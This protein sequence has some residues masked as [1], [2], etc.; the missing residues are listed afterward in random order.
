[1][2]DI[3]D[4]SYPRALDCGLY[5]PHEAIV[6]PVADFLTSCGVD[7]QFNTIVSDI[8]MDPTSE[9]KRVSAICA[10]REDER[11]HKIE[12]SP[13]DIVIVS[14]GS[15][16]S[17]T[18]AGSNTEPPSLELIE[19]EKDLDENWLLW[20][21][22]CTKNPKFGNAYN[23]C[24]RMP[25][26]RLESFTVTL[27]DHEF[28]ARFH[29]LTDNQPGSAAFV[30]LKDSRWLIS[31]N[32]P[33]QPLFPDQPDGVQVLWGY[34]LCPEAEGNFVKKSML[35]CSGEEIMTEI[36]SHLQFPVERILKNSITIPS[37]VP[38][39]TATL[40]PRTCGDRPRVIPEGM[41]NLAL[42]GH[43][44]DIPDEVV[45]TM[46]YGVRGAQMAVR[47]LMGLDVETKKSKRSL[48]INV[49]G[50]L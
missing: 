41:E 4:L 30:T 11:D 34:G 49:L 33:R 50:P 37:V 16:M 9:Q 1:M 46:D 8:V 45:V 38:R 3:H 47:Q 29:E 25:E 23:F 15:T 42:I 14:L 7:F 40:L 26:S 24:T 35:V 13:N 39:M 2:H 43:F 10:H 5:N 27:K 31:L 22:L 17:G 32:I 12:L 36:L 28:F 44:V 20:L 21:E 18:T 6:A 19:I 48:A